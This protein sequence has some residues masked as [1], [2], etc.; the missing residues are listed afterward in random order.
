MSKLV[1]KEIRLR[2]H[3]RSLQNLI[4]EREKTNGWHLVESLESRHEIVLIFRREI[5]ENTSKTTETIPEP[6]MDAPPTNPKNSVNVCL[7]YSD[8]EDGD[9]R[10][11]PE[12][13]PRAENGA[14]PTDDETKLDAMLGNFHAGGPS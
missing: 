4:T 9:V 3:L 14:P 1:E 7:H 6:I 8:G 10:I 13:I 11:V 2:G 12:I 5:P